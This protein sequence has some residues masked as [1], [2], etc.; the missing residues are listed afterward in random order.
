VFNGI[1]A[2]LQETDLPHRQPGEGQLALKVLA[3]G[4]CR[5]D[6]RIV[7]GELTEPKLPLV[8][9][10]Q[11]VG[12][13]LELGRGVTRFRP[14]Q[15]VGVPWLGWTCG[16]CRFCRSG[17]ENLCDSARFTGYTI[18][19][20][21]AEETLARC[22]LPLCGAGGVPGSAGRTTA[23]RRPDRVP[24]AATHR[25]RTPAW[26]VRVRGGGPHHLPGG[27]LAG[28]TGLVFTRPGDSQG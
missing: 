28:P 6:L 25:R 8:L 27:P 21:L 5:T 7:D 24:L 9:G 14:G 22:P 12:T 23:V 19:G 4:V 16:R 11:I 10:H 20:G 2:S 17:R 3:C 13:V 1:A 26:P 18:D 15:R